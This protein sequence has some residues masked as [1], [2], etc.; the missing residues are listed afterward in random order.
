MLPSFPYSRQAGAKHADVSAFE[1]VA[2]LAHAEPAVPMPI[3][4]MICGGS[5]AV[6]ASRLAVEEVC[7]VPVGMS[8]FDHAMEIVA[9][10]AHALPAAI[11]TQGLQQPS[12]GRRGAL[13][14]SVES[15]A[16]V[17]S[18]CTEAACQVE[19]AIEEEP[20]VGYSVV[21]TTPHSLHDAPSRRRRACSRRC[22]PS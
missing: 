3:V 20:F 4:T 21:V 12:L 7:A 11:A 18:V 13:A 9:S 6:G 5:Y 8:S 16:D 1:Y 17:L 2:Q 19:A 14:L 15:V 10:V 22:R